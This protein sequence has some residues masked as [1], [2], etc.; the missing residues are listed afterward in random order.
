MLSN[1]KKN[2]CSHINCF[3]FSSLVDRLILFSRCL[4]SPA[5]SKLGLR[6]QTVPEEPLRN[7]ILHEDEEPEDSFSDPEYGDYEQYEDTRNNI[8]AN[9]KSRMIT[10]HTVDSFID[11]GRTTNN[12]PSYA[13]M[14]AKGAQK[15]NNNNQAKN[16]V[17]MASVVGTP[18][19]SSS[20]SSGY[21]S[22]AVSC[23]NLTNDDTLSLRSMS[24]DETPGKIINQKNDFMLKVLF[25][26]HLTDF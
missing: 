19:M 3:S 14:Q 13:A 20:T 15:A 25:R 18:S 11:I 16:T 4:A 10:S 8:Y 22:Q 17:T 1:K 7:M 5:S 2:N 26:A 9:S 24:V 23:S 12:M 21:G 6:M